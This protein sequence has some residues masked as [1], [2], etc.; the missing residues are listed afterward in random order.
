MKIDKSVDCRWNKAFTLIE[1]LVVIAIIAIL[2]AMLLPALALAKGKAKRTQCI[3]NMRQI[4]SASFMYAADFADWLPVFYDPVHN[5]AAPPNDLQGTFY[6]RIAVGTE[7]VWGATNPTPPNLYLFNPKTG[8]FWQN[9]GLAYANKYVGSGQILWCPSFP[10][11]SQYGIENY[12]IPQFMST[13]RPDASGNTWVDSSYLWNPVVQNPS[14]TT[15]VNATVRAYQKTKDLPG[16]K[17]L[18]VDYLSGGMQFN[19]L[20]FPHYPSKGW[21]VLRTDGS[22]KFIYSYA[23]FTNATIGNFTANDESAFS[24][25][26]YN[27]VFNDLLAVP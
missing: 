1:L 2:A 21:D 12:S 20:N 11:G 15:A 3:S 8:P 9:L 14:N 10:A 13:A 23:A 4:G 6:S 19:Q 27:L 25:L 7:N 17:L 24:F 22:A 26:E 5:A 16:N 18:A